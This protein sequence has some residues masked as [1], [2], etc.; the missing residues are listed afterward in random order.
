[1][2][3][4]FED[5]WNDGERV[6]DLQK[7]DLAVIYKL[8]HEN[9]SNLQISSEWKESQKILGKIMLNLCSITKFQKSNAE[10]GF[11]LNSWTALEGEIDLAME[12]LVNGISKNEL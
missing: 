12:E 6:A 7:P 3:K 1:M 2:K 11:E 8:L 4:H 9:L 5:V 10:D